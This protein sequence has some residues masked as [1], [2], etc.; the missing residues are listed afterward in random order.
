MEELTIEVFQA[1]FG[2]SNYNVLRLFEGIRGVKKVR[3]YGSV[4][5]FPDYVA[6]LED[7][8][9]TKVGKE[10]VPFGGEKVVAPQVRGYD[11]WTVSGNNT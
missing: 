5:A 2:S 1:Q 6:W 4:Q 7:A 3:V 10:V 9:R 11:L 8:M